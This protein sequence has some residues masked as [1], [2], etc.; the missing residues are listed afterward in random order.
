MTVTAILKRLKTARNHIDSA[1][2]ELSVRKQFTRP[3]PGSARVSSSKRRR[4][5]AKAAK[6]GSAKALKARWS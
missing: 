4:L 5:T 2:A 1:I 3:H 6:R